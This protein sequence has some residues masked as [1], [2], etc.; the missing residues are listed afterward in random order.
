[1]VG[2]V[3]ERRIEPRCEGR[4]AASGSASRA[5]T[6]LV[7]NFHVPRVARSAELVIQQFVMSPF[8][9][10]CRLSHTPFEARQSGS[11]TEPEKV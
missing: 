10:I 5:R 2:E 11:P 6:V 9:S 1:M 3:G 4:S 8:A 7:F